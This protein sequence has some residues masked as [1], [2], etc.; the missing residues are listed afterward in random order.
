MTHPSANIRPNLSFW[1]IHGCFFGQNLKLLCDVGSIL[2][3]PY[4]E[5]TKAQFPFDFCDNFV[6]YWAQ[7]GQRAIEGQTRSFLG[8][9]RNFDGVDILGTSSLGNTNCH[10]LSVHF[11]SPIIY[12]LRVENIDRQAPNWLLGPKM[13]GLYDK[14]L[15]TG[16][17]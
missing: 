10:S 3:L 15:S 14:F 9:K 1:D 11:M 5:T 16:H 8:Q 6:Q 12:L 7:N 2:V 17:H 4:R 13:S